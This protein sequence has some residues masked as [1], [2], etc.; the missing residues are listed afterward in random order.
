MVEEMRALDKN[1]TR[2]LVD[3]P[4][5]KKP[6][7]CR[8]IFTV[9]Y[10]AN[11]SVE[12]YKARLVAKGYTQTYRIDYVETLALVA[13]MNSIKVLLSLATNQAWPFH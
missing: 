5:G 8:W 1:K 10:Q 9:K 11:G 7:E 12:K 13:K 2:E 6:V 4:R 3:L